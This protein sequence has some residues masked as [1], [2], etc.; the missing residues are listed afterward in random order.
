MPSSDWDA[1]RSLSINFL[2]RQ[3]YTTQIVSLTLLLLGS[4]ERVVRGVQVL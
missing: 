1:C 3:Q 4:G 2:L